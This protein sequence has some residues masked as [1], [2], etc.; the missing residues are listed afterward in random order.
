[1]REVE[2]DVFREEFFVGFVKELYKGLGVSVEIIYSFFMKD[3][4]CMLGTYCF[5]CLGCIREYSRYRFLFLRSEGV[6]DRELNLIN[7]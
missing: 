1:M 4:Y 5:R 3:L 7:I 6:V 2:V